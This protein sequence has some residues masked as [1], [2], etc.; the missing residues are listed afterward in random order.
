[1]LWQAMNCDSYVKSRIIY[2]Y[3]GLQSN[4]GGLLVFPLVDSQNIEILFPAVR[5]IH[6]LIKRE[7]I[8]PNN[9]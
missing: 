1:M 6:N 3:S 2:C 9:C 5:P 4:V 8:E 7:Q